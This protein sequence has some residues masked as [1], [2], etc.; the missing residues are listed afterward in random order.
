MKITKK[1]LR[2]IIKEEK[3]KILEAENNPGFVKNKREIGHGD[4]NYV[5]LWKRPQPP[6]T[7]RGKWDMFKSGV[8]GEF[9]RSM[10]SGMKGYLLQTRR[11]EGRDKIDQEDIKQL[12]AAMDDALQRII[13]EFS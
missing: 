13:K 2:K 10:R 9:Y 4:P 6:G 5:P 1:Q 11:K 8:D 3:A 7:E 12:K